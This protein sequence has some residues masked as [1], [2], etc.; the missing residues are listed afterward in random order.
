MIRRPPRP[1]RTDTLFPYTSLFRSV[2]AQ[3]GG[4]G[5]RGRLLRVAGRLEARGVG[6]LPDW[7]FD[8]THGRVPMM[9]GRAIKARG[10]CRK[11][12][13]SRHVR[14]RREAGSATIFRWTHRS[15]QD[16]APRRSKPRGSLHQVAP[17]SSGLYL[18]RFRWS[19]QV[20]RGSSECQSLYRHEAMDISAWRD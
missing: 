1:T 19:A 13:A 16:L 12:A 15:P 10:A 5:A 4:R 18:S 9:A 2:A 17:A 6:G 8:E 14:T 3:R 11:A 7:A 20:A